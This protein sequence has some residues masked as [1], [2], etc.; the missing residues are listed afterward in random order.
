MSRRRLT[1]IWDLIFFGITLF[2]LVKT[3][4][5]EEEWKFY[6]AAGAVILFLIFSLRS[7]FAQF[8]KKRKR[9]K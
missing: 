6:A 4:N 2:I 7:L 8:R 9:I 1:L 5:A 3:W